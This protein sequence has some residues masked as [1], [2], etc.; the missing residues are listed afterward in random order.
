VAQARPNGGDAFEL[1]R[2]PAEAERGTSV[3]A[4]LGEAALDLTPALVMLAGLLGLPERFV[5]P[6]D[7]EQHAGVVSAGRLERVR[8]GAQ[9]DGARHD[10]LAEND[11]VLFGREVLVLRERLAGGAARAERFDAL[12]MW[13]DDRPFGE[14]ATERRDLIGLLLQRQEA[15]ASLVALLQNAEQRKARDGR[16]SVAARQSDRGSIPE[17]DI[18]EVRDGIPESR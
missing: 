17:H 13:I 3:D 16:G 14:L 12:A 18:A 1:S 8:E 9:L 4:G 7:R 15:E 5:E 10:D 11:A 2:R 6:G